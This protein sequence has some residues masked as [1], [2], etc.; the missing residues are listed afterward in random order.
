MYSFEKIFM[1]N[2]W[3]KIM[4]IMQIVAYKGIII[5]SRME[6]AAWCDRA[7]PEW[8]YIKLNKC[9]S[10]FRSF[11]RTPTS[12]FKAHLK[13]KL[14]HI[15]LTWEKCKENVLFVVNKILSGKCLL[16][17]LKCNN[18]LWLY[19]FVVFNWHYRNTSQAFSV[20]LIYRICSSL[21]L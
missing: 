5:Y 7:G 21:T 9:K 4:H 8:S 1:K 2:S 15:F 18:C 20:H 10:R 11:Q 6:I 12:C 3:S 16:W 13:K 19:H 17:S 14:F